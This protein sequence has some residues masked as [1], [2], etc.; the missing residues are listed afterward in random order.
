MAAI[1]QWVNVNPGEEHEKPFSKSKLEDERLGRVATIQVTFDKPLPASA[2]FKIVADEDPEKIYEGNELHYPR[3]RFDPGDAQAA[4]A[5]GT[6]VAARHVELPAMGGNGYRVEATYHGTTKKSEKVYSARRRVYFAVVEMELH[7]QV[8]AAVAEE[9]KRPEGSA[10]PPNSVDVSVDDAFTHLRRQLDDKPANVFI[11]G[12][13]LER[14]N[15]GKLPHMSVDIADSADQTPFRAALKPLVRE[16]LHRRPGGAIVVVDRIAS[17]AERK[18]SEVFDP[19]VGS[20]GTL[21]VYPDTGWLVLRVDRRLWMNHS[22][23]EDAAK[24][25]LVEITATGVDASGNDV[26]VPQPLP[27]SAI[28][29][30]P[31]D[32][33]HQV[34]INLGMCKTILG[35]IRQKAPLVRLTWKLNHCLTDA[36]G[37]HFPKTNLVLVA[38]RGQYRPIPAEAV[39]GS[40][41]HEVGH[42]LGMVPDG[43][44]PAFLEKAP[45]HHDADPAEPHQDGHCKAPTCVMHYTNKKKP[46]DKKDDPEVFVRSDTF[47]GDCK[48]ILRR[49]DV[50]SASGV[51]GANVA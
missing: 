10:P 50:S 42:L 32:P 21:T 49:T 37:A 1:E 16:L 5:D 43:K 19:E 48:K 33:L 25:W 39:R 8:E 14:A 15:A 7:E 4:T 12:Y 34:E 26:D 24:H 44:A 13:K 9:R 20:S 17:K 40:M 6:K 27:R 36:A 47:C 46:K 3:F 2:K 22:P 29:P 45:N 11:D 31:Q 41:V 35:T 38:R 30:S 28:E 23:K 18:G 51:F